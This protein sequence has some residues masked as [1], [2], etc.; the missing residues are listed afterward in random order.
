KH[1]S[2]GGGVGD[3]AL[4]D[5]QLVKEDVENE[6]VSLE[7]ARTVYRVALDPKTLAI[8]PAATQALRAKR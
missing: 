1:S 8:D 2:G 3:P 6:L 4:R 7:T 5:P